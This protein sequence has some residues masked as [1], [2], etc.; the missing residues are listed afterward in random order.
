MNH[1]WKEDDHPAVRQAQI[2]DWIE[3]LAEFP[4][5][6]VA[7]ACREWRQTK[8]RRPTPV[9]IRELCIGAHR[10]AEQNRKALAAPQLSDANLRALAEEWVRDRGFDSL[11]AFLEQGHSVYVGNRFFGRKDIA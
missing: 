6:F 8:T 2:E 5:E 9:E 11:N 4:I 3:D 10:H 1:Y 7:S